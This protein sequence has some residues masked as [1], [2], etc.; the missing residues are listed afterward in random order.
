MHFL[1]VSVL[2]TETAPTAPWRY[3]ALEASCSSQLWEA[4]R[5]GGFATRESDVGA[6]LRLGMGRRA[7]P[8]IA[9]QFRIAAAGS[10]PQRRRAC[11]YGLRPDRGIVGDNSRT[12]S[13]RCA[14]ECGVLS[15]PDYPWR[16]RGS[17]TKVGC[18]MTPGL[19]AAVSNEYMASRQVRA[20]AWEALVI[21][22]HKHE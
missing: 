19:E 5:Q 10:G 9:C 21:K 16:A 7:R 18:L 13:P 1:V 2:G 15:T 8:S 11:R 14:L 6:S 4:H 17:L 20:F 22:E 12:R 3:K